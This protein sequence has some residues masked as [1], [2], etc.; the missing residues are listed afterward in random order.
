M[1]RQ[2]LNDVGVVQAKRLSELHVL[3]D[4]VAVVP[5]QSAVTFPVTQIDAESVQTVPDGQ[6]RMSAL[7]TPPKQGTKAVSVTQ[8]TPDKVPQDKQTPFVG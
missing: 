4:V 8:A 2:R 7:M 6:L 1:P 3:H 5:E